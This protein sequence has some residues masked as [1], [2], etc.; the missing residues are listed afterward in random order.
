[1]SKRASHAFETALL[2]G[3]AGAA[4]ALPL[5]AARGLGAGIGTLL[6]GLGVRRRVAESNLRLAFPER[7][8]AWRAAILA[9]HYR[10]LGRVAME[11][12]R[13]PELVAAPREQV[14]ATFEGEQHL[15]EAAALGRGVLL[16]TGHFG[17]FELCGAAL[18]RFNPVDF[19]VKPLS[20]PGADRWVA[21][22]R[23]R[24]GVGTIPLGSGVRGVFRALREG[25]WVAVLGDQ[26]AR[27]HG[28]FVPFFGRLASTPAGPAHLSL[29]TGAPLVFGTCSRAADGR[30]VLRVDPPIVPE[31]DARDP[32]A[33]R[34]LTAKHTARLETVIRERPEFWFW[35]HRRWKT[36]PPGGQ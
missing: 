31:G 32:E 11:Y 9:A 7:D 5:P 15:H 10:E 27:R 25:R 30:V 19:V 13:I 1:M 3:V 36:P 28:V 14:F 16:L 21:D 26:D 2:H 23:A 6:H 22:M 8:D 34:A 18:T 17:N 33:V 29:A 20:N 4:T 35:L 12:P 24:A